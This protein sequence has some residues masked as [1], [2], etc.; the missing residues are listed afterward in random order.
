[1]VTRFID[2]GATGDRVMR[3]Q[4]LARSRQTVQQFLRTVSEP[5]EAIVGGDSYFIWQADFVESV[6]KLFADKKVHD[7]LRRSFEEAKRGEFVEFKLP[8]PKR[9]QS[10][11]PISRMRAKP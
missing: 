2:L 9:A 6:S 11:A 8:R 5:V 1:M 4:N 7:E 3:T 10:R